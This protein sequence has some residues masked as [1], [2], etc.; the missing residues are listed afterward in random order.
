VYLS[1][2]GANQVWQLDQSGKRLRTFGKLAAQKPGSFDRETFMR[3][4]KLATWRDKEG[5]DRLLV[6][7]SA[8]PNHVTE[9]SADGKL[10]RDFLPLQTR[11]NDGYGVDPEH[12]EHIYLPTH[13]G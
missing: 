12:P 5:N 10:L 1:I 4:T 13:G 3:P 8:G 2:P 7:D 9:W 11:A 6:M